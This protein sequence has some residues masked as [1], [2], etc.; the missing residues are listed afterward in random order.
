MKIFEGK[1]KSWKW[2]EIIGKY[3]GGADT[4]TTPTR[5]AVRAGLET[6]ETGTVT[7]PTRGEYL[8]VEPLR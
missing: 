2:I 3:E 7:T 5:G 4:V 1:S 6:L 8:S